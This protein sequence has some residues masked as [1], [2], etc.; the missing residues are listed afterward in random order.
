MTTLLIRH[1]DLLVTMDDQRREIPDGGLFIRDGF[2]EQV[3]PTAG[4]PETAGE[5]LDL[6]GHILLPEGCRQVSA[7]YLHGFMPG[8]FSPFQEIP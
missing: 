6:N 2:I 5:I 7:L 4:L 1:A 3:G 8:S